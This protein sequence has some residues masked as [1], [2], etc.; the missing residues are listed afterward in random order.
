M[1]W[2]LGQ[3]K[4]RLIEVQHEVAELGR[5]AKAEAAKRVEKAVNLCLDSKRGEDLASNTLSDAGLTLKTVAGS[6]RDARPSSSDV[7]CTA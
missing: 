3:K 2:E 6:L 7:T 5:T 4:A 1:S